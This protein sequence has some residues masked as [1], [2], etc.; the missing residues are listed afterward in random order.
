M[1]TDCSARIAPAISVVAEAA[2][3][4]SGVIVG[5]GVAGAA[6]VSVV[7]FVASIGAHSCG[8]E[9]DL[10]D[11]ESSDHNSKEA[12]PNNH[13]LMQ[14]RQKSRREEE[15][16]GTKEHKPRQPDRRT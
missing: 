10:D 13:H 2:A 1:L 8:I 14:K 4:L 5:A 12:K 15:E 9:F 11:G 7:T 16:S 6:A 3:V